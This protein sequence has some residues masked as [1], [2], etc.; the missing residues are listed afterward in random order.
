MLV[1]AAVLACT[2][3]SSSAPTPTASPE[4]TPQL[5]P[6]AT[7]AGL[8]PAEPDTKR[9]LEHIRFL[10]EEIGPRPAGSP[11]EEAV[12]AYAREQFERSGYDVE[13]QPFAV[14]RPD[15]LRPATLSV[16]LPRQ[17]ELPAVSL[18]GSAAGEVS[19]RLLDAGTGREEDFTSDMGGAVVLIQRRDVFFREMA[20]RAQAAG[21]VAVVIANREPDLFI[22]EIDPPTTLLVLAIDQ[23]DGEALR[24]LLAA[25]A[26]EVRVRVEGRDD[27]TARNII[28]RPASGE[29]RTLSGGHYDSVPWTA[30]ANDNASGSALVLELARAAAAA[31]LSGHCFA[32]FGAEELG[33][34]GSAFFISELTEGERDALEAV[35]NYDVV[36]GDARLLAISN[37]GE[38][39]DRAL[40][41]ANEMELSLDSTTSV[42][43]IGSDH[44]SFL[45]AGIP[46]LMLTT[47][48]FDLIHSVRDTLAGIESAPLGMIASLAFALLAEAGEA[49]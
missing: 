39:L 16:D 36:A 19:G 30:G 3:D 37:P 32:L 9:I 8:G 38:L 48:D 33:L 42:E 46:T 25:G 2:G 24:D 4:A 40:A 22:G 43:D 41:L 49:A 6:T 1:A 10:S 29:C 47:P 26:V 21:A 45:D 7:A 5:S 35:Y 44:R 15:F 28:A 20:R 12:I 31:G 14:E 23:A 11:E 13:V 17:Q 18:T 27:V 34:L